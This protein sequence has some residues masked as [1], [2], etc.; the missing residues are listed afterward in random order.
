MLS[1]FYSTQAIGFCGDS[2]KSGQLM[3]ARARRERARSC[4][5]SGGRGRERGWRGGSRVSFR[6]LGVRP[7]SVDTHVDDSV[8]RLSTGC[9]HQQQKARLLASG[10]WQ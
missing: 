7:L 4:A 8:F 6:L 10:F 5:R 1:G 3:P 2:E 9:L